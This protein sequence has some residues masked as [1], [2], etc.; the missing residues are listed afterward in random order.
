MLVYARNVLK[1]ERLLETDLQ[2]LTRGDQFRIGY[3]GT[4]AAMLLSPSLPELTAANPK[5]GISLIYAAASSLPNMLRAGEIDAYIIS[6]AERPP[7]YLCEVLYYTSFNYFCHR[8]LFT[9]YCSEEEFFEMPYDER[10]KIIAEIPFSTA[11]KNYPLR[12]THDT[13]FEKH[14]LT[15]NYVSSATS[16][17]MNLDICRC[18][19]AGI[20]LPQEMIDKLLPTEERAS[21]ITMP[22]PDM[23]EIEPL[24]FVCKKDAGNIYAQDIIRILKKYCLKQKEKA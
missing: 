8:D 15:P 24:T 18:R 23:P 2:T 7:E 5:T 16:A 19:N 14:R 3:S 13:Y 11:P 17:S 20:V 22:L 12:K 1:E 10:I 4:K 6:S 21:Y 9:R